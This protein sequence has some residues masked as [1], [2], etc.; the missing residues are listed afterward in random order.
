LESR[1]DCI[2]NRSDFG[3]VGIKKSRLCKGGKQ[4]SVV[5]MELYFELLD[6]LKNA[7][8]D[9]NMFFVLYV[10]TLVACVYMSYL[11]GVW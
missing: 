9:R 2:C 10:I 8:Q 7:R 3:S 1:N 5:D 4:Q 6:D 11:L